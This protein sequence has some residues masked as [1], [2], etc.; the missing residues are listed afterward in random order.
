MKKIIETLVLSVFVVL[1]TA[2]FGLAEYAATSV[3]D[4]PYFQFGCLVVGALTI[5]SLRHKYHKMYT[6]ELVAIFCLYTVLIALFTVP[7]I[8]AIKTVVS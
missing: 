6:R 5:V 4:F 7:V 8:S 1:V 2:T 3:K